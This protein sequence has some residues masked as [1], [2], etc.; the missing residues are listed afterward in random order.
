MYMFCNLLAIISLFVFFIGYGAGWDIILPAGWSMPF[1]IS[2]VYR[3]ARVG[4]LRESKNSSLESEVPHFPHDV[5]DTQA[6]KNYNNEIQNE[7]EMKYSRYPPDKRPNY[8]KLGI[9][10]PFS[11]PWNKLV[12]EW[13]VESEKQSLIANSSLDKESGKMLEKSDL[14]PT[15]SDTVTN[16][17]KASPSNFE[18]L[19]TNTDSIDGKEVF[20]NERFYVLRDISKV[21]HL[22]DMFKEPSNKRK[23]TQCT[24]DS[25]NLNHLTNIIDNSLNAL[26]AV[27]L[28]MVNQGFPLPNATISIPSIS[29]LKELKKCKKFGGPTEPLHKG[30]R[31]HFSSNVSNV[32]TL[33]GSCTRDVIGFVTSAQYSLSRGYGVGIGYCALPG[34]ARLLL[35]GR[36]GM[37]LVRNTSSQQYRFAYISVLSFCF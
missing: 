29:D 36:E 23:E 25:L 14:A 30:P 26:A 10:S 33:I 16:D 12:K 9:A 13:A 24:E 35:T 32:N 37:V 34:L 7:G 17:T 21:R 20:C 22:R 5:P 15:T 6:G 1:W 4:G 8:E 2:L 31:H 11:S 19:Q 3:G 27:S 28:R 18:S